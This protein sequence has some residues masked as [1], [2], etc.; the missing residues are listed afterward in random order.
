M[1]GLAF[2]DFDALP[3]TLAVDRF[4][5]LLA[6]AAGATDL[7]QTLAVRCVQLAIPAE[8]TEPMIVAIQGLQFMFRGRRVYDQTMPAAFVET[9]DGAVQNGM[10]T[11]TQN[12]VGSESHNGV[13]KDQ[14]STQGTVNVIDQSGNIALGFFVD[15][16]WPS[17]LGAVQ[18]DG[19]AAQPY[20]QTV[21]FTFDR[22]Q[23][24][25]GVSMS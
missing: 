13:T 18:L 15:N 10:R 22:L 2:S 21:T 4:E 19:A 3:D 7:N 25:V 17:D 23:P 20:I 6:P 5:I 16:I 11:W 24:P 8:I 1:A 9:T 14:Y 12:I